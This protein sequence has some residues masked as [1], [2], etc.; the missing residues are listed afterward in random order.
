MAVNS[1]PFRY[2]LATNS[3]STGFTAQ[4]ATS[5]EPSG[6]GVIDLGSESLGLG[7]EFSVPTYIQLIPFG[8]NGEDDTFDMRV[9][10]YSKTV[11][12]N[13]VT[14][15]ALYIPQ[16]LIDVSV[17]L[18]ALTF[19]DHAANTFLPDTLTINDGAADNGPWRSF[20]NPAEDLAA[21]V[22]VHTRGCRYLKWDW[23]LA[24][25]QEA[26]SMNCM[27]RAFEF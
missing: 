8:T 4:N 3:T 22:I 5:T 6:T 27:Y 7:S 25:A 17:V 19:S 26:V 1:Q 2:V 15:T 18:S 24:G 21:S 12:T 20:I 11:P 10:G 16:L 23:D 13:L 14:D 9:Y